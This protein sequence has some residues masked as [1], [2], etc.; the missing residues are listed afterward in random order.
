MNVI[1]QIIK[2]PISIGISCDILPLNRAGCNTFCDLFSE[3]HVEHYHREHADYQGGELF[4]EVGGECAGELVDSDRQGLELKC[5]NQDV[6]DH[7]LVPGSGYLQYRNSDSYG[8][9]NW[10]DDAA[11]DAEVFGAVYAGRFEYFVRYALDVFCAQID[12]DRQAYAD[13]GNQHSQ[14]CI[15]ETYGVDH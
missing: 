8:R 11:E 9:G 4:A 6:D 14:S 7:E 13:I 2:K 3:Y 1:I 5:G 10:Q 15:V 12:S